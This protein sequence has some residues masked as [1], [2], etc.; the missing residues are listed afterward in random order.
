[1]QRYDSSGA[2]KLKRQF[3]GRN[4]FGHHLDLMADGIIPKTIKNIFNLSKEF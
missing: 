1:V 2:V 3:T 4:S